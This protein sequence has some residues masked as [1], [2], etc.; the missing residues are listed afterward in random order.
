MTGD[1]R[2]D[3]AQEALLRLTVRF[4]RWSPD[5]GEFPAWAATVARNLAVDYLRRDK[6]ALAALGEDAQAVGDDA[7]VDAIVAV[8]DADLIDSLFRRLTARGDTQ[9][10]RVLAAIRD[11]VGTGK[12]NTHQAVAAAAGVSESTV[13]RALIRIRAVALELG[14]EM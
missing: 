7:A 4:G 9:A 1:N 11:L 14:E 2:D 13:R 10:Q 6:D 8:D 3:V 12:P 5:K